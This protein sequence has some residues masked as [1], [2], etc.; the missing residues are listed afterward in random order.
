MSADRQCSQHIKSPHRDPSIF[1]IC[2]T[3]RSH[4]DTSRPQAR[5]LVVHPLWSFQFGEV[6]SLKQYRYLKIFALHNRIDNHLLK[7]Q[8]SGSLIPLI[9]EHTQLIYIALHAV[10][11]DGIYR[12]QNRQLTLRLKILNK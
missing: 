5:R 10:Y 6:T 9:V 3:L 12:A 1:G 8:C 7:P 2:H 11:L 4:A